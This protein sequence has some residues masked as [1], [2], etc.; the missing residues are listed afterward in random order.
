MAEDRK[1]RS[2]TKDWG[3]EKEDEKGE[4]AMETGKKLPGCWMKE[5]KGMWA[6]TA[7]AA[8]KLKKE[9][10]LSNIH[11]KEEERAGVA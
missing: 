5:E 4:L 7:W 9:W 8:E 11:G 10:D 1:K 2:Q 3:Q 6:L